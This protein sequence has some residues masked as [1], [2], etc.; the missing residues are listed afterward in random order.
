[1]TVRREQSEVFKAP[2][3]KVIG[4][5]R[6]ALADKLDTCSFKHTVE[7]EDH[8]VFN[9]VA[10]PSWWPLVLETKMNISLEPG[11]SQT[12]VTVRIRSQWFLLGDAFDYYGGYIYDI[13]KA[14]RR[15][16]E[17]EAKLS[18]PATETP[19]TRFSS[20]H[21]FKDA[22]RKCLQ[23]V[24]FPV[25]FSLL[26]LLGLMLGSLAAIEVLESGW[27][28]A[29]D[30]GNAVGDVIFSVWTTGALLAILLTIILLMLYIK[31]RALAFGLVCSRC[32]ATFLLSLRPIAVA[33]G[34][35][36]RCGLRLF[37]EDEP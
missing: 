1:M 8:L 32:D 3:A 27:G 26:G 15:R 28:G 18:V 29:A 33:I 5:I 23:A 24:V 9:T 17:G 30:H 25:F 14:I 22:I 6:S 37:P 19:N 34:R 4:A 21:Q 11:E 13:L 31:K 7:A 10:R 35:C 16:V 12:K 36:G 2:S 20:R